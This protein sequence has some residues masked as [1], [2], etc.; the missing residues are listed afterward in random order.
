[1]LV[2]APEVLIVCVSDKSKSAFAIIRFNR[3]TYVS[4]GVVAVVSGRSAAEKRLLEFES[5]QTEED[6]YAGWR[7]FLEESDLAP[8]TEP[9][10]ATRM[11]QARLDRLDSEA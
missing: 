4:G 11:R 2:Y 1:L 9:E 6:R 7:Y 10:K 8:G 5:G 3:R